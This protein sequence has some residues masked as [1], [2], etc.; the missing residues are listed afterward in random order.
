MLARMWRKRNTPPLLVG[1]K[2]CTTTLE[3]SL[4][5]PQKKMDIVLPEDPAIP[6]MVFFYMKIL[7]KSYKK[8]FSKECECGFPYRQVCVKH[9]K[10]TIKRLGKSKI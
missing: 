4:A 6:L 9:M 5:V 10:N 7:I 8:N 3:I 2:A 1:L